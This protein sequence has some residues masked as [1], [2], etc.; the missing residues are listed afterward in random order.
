MKSISRRS[1]L[2]TAGAVT[3]WAG[4]HR[5]ALGAETAAGVADRIRGLMFGSAI[6]DALGGPIEFQA[7]AEV[8]KLAHP[9]KLWREGEKLDAAARAAAAGRLRL[10]SYRDLRPGTESYGQWNPH[11]MP[12]TITD[13]TRHKLVF[14]HAL[15]Q[16]ERENRWPLTVQD[17]ARAYLE[18]PGTRAVIG[19]PGYEELARDWLEEWQ[20]GARW[21][22]GERALGKAFPPERMWQSLPTCCGQMVLLPMAALFAGQPEAAYRAAYY[23]GFFDNGFGKD[24]NAALVAGLAQALTVPAGL[25]ARPAFEKVLAT[26][27]ETD[28]LRFRQIRWSERAVDRWLNLALRLARDARQE[29]ARLF[30]ALEKEF[31]Q[32]TKWEAQVPFVVVFACFELAECDPLAALQL[33]MEWG[34]DTDSY[35]QVAGALAGALHGSALF[36]P[37]TQPVASRLEADHGFDLEAECRFLEQLRGQAGRQTMVAAW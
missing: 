6:G 26:M 23:L 4:M 11:S 21:V 29:P 15:R 9:T 27:R 20:F 12:G 18:W 32:T 2:E 19:R 25:G 24:L 30:A 13:D 17:L 22:L 31:E 33:T 37:W 10:R 5:S 34:H 36:A 28:P 3:V 35:A 1:F 16:A 14:I 8:Q 7:L